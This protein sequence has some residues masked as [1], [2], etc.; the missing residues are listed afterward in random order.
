MTRDEAEAFLADA[1]HSHDGAFPLFE[2]AIACSIHEDPER[3]PDVA[4]HLAE[5]G[6][7]RLTRAAAPT[8]RHRQSP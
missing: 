7:K 4:R 8:S 2:A 5:E 3:D 6:A 1:G